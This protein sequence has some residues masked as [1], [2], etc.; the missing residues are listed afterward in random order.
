[1]CNFVVALYSI[2]GLSHPS[3]L[4]SG[5]ETFWQSGFGRKAFYIQIVLNAEKIILNISN[6]IL[7]IGD[8]IYSVFRLLTSVEV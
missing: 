8:S 6:G 5:R 7:V 3:A 1:M 4:S 2:E